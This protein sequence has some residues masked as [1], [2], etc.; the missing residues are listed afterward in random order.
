MLL[1]GCSSKGPAADVRLNQIQVIGTHN[2]YHLR[3]HES[4]RT[5]LAQRFPQ[6][7]QGLDYAHLPLPEQLSR[8][9]IRQIEL[10]CFADPQGG[11]YAEPRGVKWAADA[12][13]PA[14]PNQD[15]EGRLRQPGLKVMHVQDIDYFSSC[16]TLVDGLRQVRAWSIQHPRHVPIFILVELKEDQPSSLLTAPVAFG[17]AELAALEAE[18]LSVFPRNEILTPDDVRG[19]EPSLPEA[20]RKSGWPKLQAVRG[21]VMFGMDNQSAVR[22]LY[23]K[24]HEALEGR[25]LFVS[26]PPD[27]PAAAWMKENDAITDFQHIQDLVRAGFLVRTRADA[28]TVEARANDTRRRD[29]ALASGAQFISTDYPEP[30]RRFTP[31]AVRFENGIVVRSNP[32]NG[33]PGLRGCEL[34]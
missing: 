5:L 19:A 32:V 16:L 13:L 28:D 3:A 23:L 1:A 10:D 6:E 26:V 24:G 21:R 8:Q 30:D 12:G 17:E 22:D 27:N 11:L 18:I 14:V 15:P 2:S 34:E 29:R 9:R 20:L 33:N 31:Y 25:L 7:A 4:L